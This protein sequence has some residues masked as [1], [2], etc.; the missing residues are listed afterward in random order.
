MT[1]M[2]AAVFCGDGRIELETT[3]MPEPGPDELCVRLEGC[4][5]CASNLPVWSG[6]P[7]FR[8]PLA[9]GAPGHEGWGEIVSIGEAVEDHKVGERVALLSG[10][11][12]AEYDIAA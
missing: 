10:K 12:Y 6:Q 9:P 1:R 7:W 2:Q 5:I 4:G 3:A 8:Y 11:A